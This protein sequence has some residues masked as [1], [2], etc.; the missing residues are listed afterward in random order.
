MNELS[1]YS[2]AGGGLLGTHL[3]GW[4]VKGYVEIDD[5]CQ[6][7]LAQRIADG[8][9]PV[10]PIF[11]DV[12]QFIQ[13][14][15]AAQ[16]RGFI[17]VVTGGFPCQPFSDAGK[18][19][20]ANDPRNMWPATAECVRIIRPEFCFFENVPALLRSGYFG[21]IVADLAES[22][23]RVR[24][25]LLSARKLGAPHKRDRVWV[26]ATHHSSKRRE[27]SRRKK[28]QGFSGLPWGENV[29]S[30]EELLG[31]S[32]IPEPLVRRL[33]NE[34]PFGVERLRAIGNGQVPGVVRTAWEI[35]SGGTGDE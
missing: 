4:T 25:C 31:R 3:L 11:G 16:Y 13:S 14:G 19:A 28:I 9:L 26:A 5:Y 22:G 32:S 23:Y 27:G 18:R 24:W 12:R 10:A 2:G 1:L 7:V 20:G 21:R 17:D 15:A 8:Y 30:V 29:G 34:F 35:L 33:G 6:R